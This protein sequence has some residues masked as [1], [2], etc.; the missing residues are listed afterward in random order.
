MKSVLAAA[1]DVFS[2]VAKFVRRGLPNPT[3]G[4]VAAIFLD[5]LGE[6]V[7]SEV[8]V[9][10]DEAMRF[11]TDKASLGVGLSG[12]VGFPATTA[13]TQSVASLHT[14]SIPSYEAI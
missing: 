10:V 5:P 14:L 7:A 11:A 4:F 1:A 6:R 12:S 13:L 9:P 8:P 2:S 3:G